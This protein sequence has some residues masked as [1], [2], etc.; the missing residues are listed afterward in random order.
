MAR[1]GI[2]RLNGEKRIGVETRSC[3]RDIVTQVGRYDVVRVME[4]RG[5]TVK[6]V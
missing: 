4:R 6:S 1:E 5:L 2:E 3:A